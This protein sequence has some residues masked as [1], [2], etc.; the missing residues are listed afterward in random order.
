MM[1]ASAV[2]VQ[3][4]GGVALLIWAV[5]MVRTGVVRAFG[6]SLR[7]VLASATRTGRWRPLPAPASRC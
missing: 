3:L 4:I 1:S 5:R 2:F 7:A 6:S